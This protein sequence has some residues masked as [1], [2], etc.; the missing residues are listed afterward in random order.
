MF[1]ILY[2][3]NNNKNYERHTFDWVVTKEDAT[4]AAKQ[5][6]DVD[7]A[8]FYDISTTKDNTFMTIADLAMDFN[9]D[10]VSVGN[11]WTVYLDLTEEEMIKA[12][13]D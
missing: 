9:D 2:P 5:L 4:K 7:K 3:V 11:Y 6:N 8:L 1:L 12:I 10:Q 13:K